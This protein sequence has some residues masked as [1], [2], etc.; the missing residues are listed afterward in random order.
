M[1]NFMYVDFENI[2]KEAEL[3]S[4][5]SRFIKSNEDWEI[6][7]FIGQNQT[8]QQNQIAITS[9]KTTPIRIYPIDKTGKNALDINLV[10]YLGKIIE[11]FGDNAFHYIISND[12]IYDNLNEKNIKRIDSPKKGDLEDV[13]DKYI[14]EIDALP[15]KP[16]K[17]KSMRNFL[18]G[19]KDIP[20]NMREKIIN[21]YFCNKQ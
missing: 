4:I 5:F 17:E 19:K 21:Y 16:R 8:K 2:N 14:K 1:K 6:V 11:K 3:N 13:D 15:N 18:K 10:L 20:E 12:K 7:Y 9:H